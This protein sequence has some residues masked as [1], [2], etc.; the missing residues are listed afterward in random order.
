MDIDSSIATLPRT[1]SLTIQKFKSLQIIS[2]ADLLNYFPTRYEDYSLISPIKELG[3]YFTIDGEKKQKVTI[4]GTVDSMKNVFTRRGFKLQTAAISD[5]SGTVEI[6]WFNQYYLINLIKA[7]QKI[8]L[9]GTVKPDKRGYSLQ[10]EEFELLDGIKEPIHTGRLVPIYSEKAGLSNKTIREKIHAVLG[11]LQNTDASIVPDSIATSVNLIGAS[12]AYRAIHFPQNL[13]AA[14]KAR[15]R[16][17]FDELFVMQLAAR[18]IRNK[19]HDRKASKTIFINDNTQKELDNF[20]SSLPFSL[21]GAQIRALNEI[22]SDLVKPHPMNRLLQ[23][24]VGSGKTVIGALAAYIVALNGYK[25]LFMAPTEVLALQHFETIQKLFKKHNKVFIAVYTGSHKSS[26]EELEKASIIVGTH[27]LISSK[28][29]TEN[30]GLI[31]VDEQHKFGVAQRQELKSKSSSPHLLSMTATP[32]PRTVSL[33]L[34]GELDISI[35]D[36]LPKGRLQIK[37]HVVS[38]TKRE[39]GYKWIVQE[40][41]KHKTQVFIVCPLIDESESETLKEVKAVKAEFDMLSKGPLKQ[42]TLSLLHGRLNSKE[43]ESVMNE[44]AVGKSDVLVS[45]PV[46]EVGVDIPNATIMIVEAAERFGLSQLHQLR[47]RVGRGDK[48]SYCFLFTEKTDE[49]IIKRLQFFAKT[50]NGFELAEYDLKQRGSGDIFGLKQ[51]GLSKLRIASFND[52]PM[53]KL[54]GQAA[55][56][57][58]KDFDVSKYPK[59]LSK[60]E[61]FETDK[62]AN[63]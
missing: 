43:K 54:S 53:V 44:F 9:S 8:S 13:E 1:S 51:H 27:A 17:S 21:T 48:Q 63:D 14:Q 25:T 46:V 2:I 15:A 34:Y 23:G 26:R 41:K 19:W 42:V 31:I 40:I 7:G 61:Q 37:S 4:V 56:N 60:V 18:I 20:I 35:I 30:V 50:N 45:T 33:T 29:Q 24:D 55:N 52:L 6:V 28:F 39:D 47:G 32:I 58:I 10:V 59:L 12:G 49:D 3:R 5:N 57:F 36:K 11:E 22:K 62:I 38:P 16:L